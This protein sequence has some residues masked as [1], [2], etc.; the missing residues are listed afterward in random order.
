LLNLPSK[1]EG[2]EKEEGRCKGVG[3]DDE[4]KVIDAL[5]HS[6]FAESVDDHIH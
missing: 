1:D 3:V 5:L 6:C 4:Y 2:K